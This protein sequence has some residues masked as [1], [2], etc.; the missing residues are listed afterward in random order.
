MP[1]QEIFASVR[2]LQQDI[3]ELRWDIAMKRGNV[4]KGAIDHL[5][6]YYAN[7]SNKYSF[8]HEVEK[9]Y[10]ERREMPADAILAIVQLAGELDPYEANSLIAGIGC[11]M[12]TKL[13]AVEGGDYDEP[14]ILLPPDEGIKERSPDFYDQCQRFYEYCVAEHNYEHR[15][16]D[17]VVSP[18][19]DKRTQKRAG[20]SGSMQ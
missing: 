5:I 12:R 1:N 15:Y 19:I 17:E 18:Y 4:P 13:N 14:L 11:M 2:K 10:L 8:V 6:N 3:E 16:W 20:L 7:C 9:I